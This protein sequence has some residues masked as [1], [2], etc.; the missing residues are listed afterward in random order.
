MCSACV[1][2]L[3]WWQPESIGDNVA[4]SAR[5]STLGGEKKA[6]DFDTH[7]L[8]ECNPNIYPDAFHANVFV[9]VIFCFK[10]LACVCMAWVVYYF[11]V[12]WVNMWI[13]VIWVNMW[14]RVGCLS[15]VK[16]VLPKQHPIAHRQSNC[17]I[18]Y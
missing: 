12:I 4:A 3:V 7:F 2:L 15:R 14:V 8:M 16:N 1:Y 9:K 17:P 13:R 5:T 18:T 11:Y 6:R 10:S